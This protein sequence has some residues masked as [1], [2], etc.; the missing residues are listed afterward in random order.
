MEKIRVRRG[1]S[2]AGIGLFATDTF[3]R[4]ECVIE[5]T[6]EHITHEEADKRGGKYLF[7]L[8]KKTVVDGKGRENLGRYINHSCKP[9]AEAEVDEDMQKIYI[10]AKRKIAIGEEITYDYGKEYW[11]EYI[12]PKGC[13]CDA[14]IISRA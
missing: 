13:M 9:N 6:G 3:L 8:D 1:K 12:K 10:K 2:R 5:Y 14:C 11:K 4:G 7:I